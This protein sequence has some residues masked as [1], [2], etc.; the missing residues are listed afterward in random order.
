M[1][2]LGWGRAWVWMLRVRLCG[3]KVV[4]KLELGCRI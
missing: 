3:K 1:G 4:G 2:M